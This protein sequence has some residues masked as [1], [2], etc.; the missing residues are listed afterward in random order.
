MKYSKYNRLMKAFRYHENAD[1]KWLLTEKYSNLSLQS[2][3]WEYWLYWYC[4]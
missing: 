1:F 2:L 3:P 4:F